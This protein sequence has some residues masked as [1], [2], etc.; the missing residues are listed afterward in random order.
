MRDNLKMFLYIG[1]IVL[2]LTGCSLE[3]RAAIN[4]AHEGA[5]AIYD[6]EAKLLMMA[7]CAM[8]VGS[9]WR[10]LNS[11]QRAAVDLLCGK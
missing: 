8:N 9:Y 2:A 11:Q 7:P 3:Q 5:L 4:Y 6:T 1:F 10:V